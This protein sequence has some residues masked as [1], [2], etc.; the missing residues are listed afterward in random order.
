MTDGQI[1]GLV[2]AGITPWVTIFHWDHPLEL[3]KRY[4]GF[5]DDKDIV[6]DFVSF[7][8]LC[9]DRFGD[10]VKHWITINEASWTF[11][12]PRILSR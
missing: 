2:A 8:K 7:A 10:R 1:D 11:D 4:G 5:Y 6:E 3:E 12:I 9:F